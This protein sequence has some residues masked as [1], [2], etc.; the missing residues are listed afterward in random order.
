VVEECF[1]LGSLEEV[2]AALE[3]AAADHDSDAHRYGQMHMCL[4]VF[5]YVCACECV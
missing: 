1:G 3:K 5:V 4:H 2:V